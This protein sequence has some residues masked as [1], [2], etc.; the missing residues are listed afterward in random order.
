MHEALRVLHGYVSRPVRLPEYDWG[1]S[2]LVP[3]LR[4]HIAGHVRELAQIRPPPES[5][6][7]YRALGGLAQNL[8]LVRARGPYREVCRELTAHL[9]VG[10]ASAASAG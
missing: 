4:S 7:F 9:S 3:E 6:F 5:V 8:K 2:T 1:S 10:T